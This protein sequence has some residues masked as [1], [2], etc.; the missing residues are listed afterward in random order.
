EENP[1][2]EPEV[3]PEEEEA[4]DN[5]SDLPLEL[6]QVPDKDDDD[7]KTMTPEDLIATE[8]PPSPS[9]PPHT[10]PKPSNNKPPL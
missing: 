2:E 1:E 4:T 7:E 8:E 3:G 10:E 5:V 6:L 9:L